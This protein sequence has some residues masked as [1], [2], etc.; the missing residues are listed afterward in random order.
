M[1]LLKHWLATSF[2]GLLLSQFAFDALAHEVELTKEAEAAKTVTA[3]T[4]PPG[5]GDHVWFLGQLGTVKSSVEETGAAYG[6]V[7]IS[8][9][10]NFAPGAHIHLR[11]DESF[12]LL[13]GSMTFF[14]GDEEFDVTPGTFVFSPKGVPHR[15]TVTSATPAK[16]LLFHGPT[17][18]FRRFIQEVGTEAIDP[19]W[20]PRAQNVDPADVAEIA[21]K[22]FIEP[23]PS[24]EKR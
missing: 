24:T 8:A 5:K 19:V 23:V 3:F 2:M 22:H 18:D 6:A 4:I 12:F 13:E 9:T 20:P 11:E 7:L 21:R 16:W 10:P 17:G 1:I 15:F 14:A